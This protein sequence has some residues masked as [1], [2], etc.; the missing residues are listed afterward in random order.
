MY[1]KR[2]CTTPSYT[3]CELWG[4][5]M[6]GQ[7]LHSMILV[8]PFQFGTFY[9]SHGQ[10]LHTPNVFYVPYA[11]RYLC[12]LHPWLLQPGLAPEPIVH[13][14][15]RGFVAHPKRDGDVLVTPSLG[16]KVSDNAM[17]QWRPFLYWTFL[18]AFEGL[19][20]FFGA[21]FLFQN[22]SLEDNGKVTPRKKKK[23][24]V[25]VARTA[26][27]IYLAGNIYML[28][29]CGVSWV[30]S[31]GVALLMVWFCSKCLK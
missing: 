17:L 2:D 30:L 18:G 26:S 29:L 9:D 20:F 8:G 11:G 7:E 13:L 19:V 6:Q 31:D 28:N 24:S 14:A 10:Q 12:G 22:S 5:P 4:C 15:A 27:F 1:S 3:R 16:R 21:Y 25:S 23:M